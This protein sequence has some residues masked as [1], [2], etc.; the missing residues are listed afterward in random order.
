MAPPGT[1]ILYTGSGTDYVQA[2]Y[3]NDTIYCGPGTNQID[4]GPGTTTAIFA[5]NY[6]DY[7][8]TFANG[9][10]TIIG[11]EGTSSLANIETIKFNDG[12]YNVL[13][14]LVQTG[15]RI[16]LGVELLEPSIRT[17]A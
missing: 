5:G 7:G 3:G 11:I 1:D 6:A 9:V 8:R 14:G 15:P 12:S 13:T 16:A 4:G 2:D 17:V 10:T